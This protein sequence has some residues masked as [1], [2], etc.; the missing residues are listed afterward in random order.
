MKSKKSSKIHS[1][2]KR[3]RFGFVYVMSGD[4]SAPCKIGHTN[5]IKRR[6]KAM[7]TYQPTKVRVHYTKKCSSI[8]RAKRLEFLV[9]QHLQEHRL[10]GEWFNLSPYECKK[11]I[12]EMV[13]KYKSF[14]LK[15]MDAVLK[16]EKKKQKN[17]K[18][19]SNKDSKHPTHKKRKSIIDANKKLAEKQRDILKGK[20]FE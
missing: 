20:W 8:W 10:M 17:N 7:Q 3:E 15:E 13:S 12:N 14:S 6:V 2:F 19:Y 18:S 5:N 9:H 4:N 16:P 1:K 11:S